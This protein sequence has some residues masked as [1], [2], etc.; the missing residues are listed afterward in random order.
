M[1]APRKSLKEKLG[2]GNAAPEEAAPVSIPAAD[3][4]TAKANAA[5]EGILAIERLVADCTNLARANEALSRRNEYLYNVNIKERENADINQQKYEHHMRLNAE[6]AAYITQ[7]RDLGNRIY[8]L[9]VQN[10]ALVHRMPSPQ[11]TTN[12]PTPEPEEE[13]AQFDSNGIP[14][15]AATPNSISNEERDRLIQRLE[16]TT[17]G[18]A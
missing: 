11:H 9:L 5:K 10:A 17:G 14:Y 2:Y 1:S 4:A 8:T 6:L 3:P 15:N 16:E 13:E 12:N 18:N 7:L